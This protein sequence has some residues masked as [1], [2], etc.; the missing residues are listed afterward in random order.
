VP[1]LHHRHD[2]QRTL[3]TG[4]AIGTSPTTGRD[5]DVEWVGQSYRSAVVP[6]PDG[7]AAS[8]A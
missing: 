1:D 7:S 6:I 8:S 5:R 4:T 3:A 2:H